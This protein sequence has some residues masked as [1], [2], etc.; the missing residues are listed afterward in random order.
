MLTTRRNSNDIITYTKIS[1]NPLEPK[2]EDIDI[3]D[4]AHALSYMCRANGHIK[5]F[6]SVAQHCINCAVEAGFREYSKRVQLACL[7]H[8]ASEAYIADITRPVKH[9]LSDYI[10]FEE[11]L[12]SLIYMKYGLS[13]LNEME[14]RQIDDIDNAFLHHEFIQLANEQI[15]TEEPEIFGQPNY[16]L[17]NFIDVENEYLALFESLK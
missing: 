17:R 10:V 4:I 9:N 13:D 15:Y 7:L 1:M 6:F 3:Q 2:L 5:I 16:K 14:N 11:R 8:D 12:Q